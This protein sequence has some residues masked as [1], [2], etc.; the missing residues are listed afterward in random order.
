MRETF[1]AQVRWL[2]PFPRQQ[3]EEEEEEE[4]ITKKKTK[5]SKKKKN[6]KS[7]KQSLLLQVY[8]GKCHHS[9]IGLFS[10]N[11]SLNDCS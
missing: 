8:V 4:R 9:N 6:C 3:Q 11:L 10:S 7:V 2:Q 5:K 1:L